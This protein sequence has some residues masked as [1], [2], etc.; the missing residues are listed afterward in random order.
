LPADVEHLTA[1]AIEHRPEL[2]AQHAVIA[3]EESNLARARLDYLPDFEV[4]ASRFFNA[5]RRDGFGGMVSVSLPLVHKGKYDAAVRE[6]TA[7]LDA[8]RADERRVENRIRR[9][10]A[11]AH[12]RTATARAQHALYQTSHI[13]LAEQSLQATESAY[14]TSQSDLT[15]VLESVR[16]IEDVHL[17]HVAFAAAFEKAYAELER[18]VGT[19]LPR[20]GG[21]DATTPPTAATV[22]P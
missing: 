19:E 14:Q 11:Q 16:M 6:I 22:R 21:D 15:A 18:A 8:A 13:P 2:A 20:G 17:E 3:R 10:V 7:R 12:L 5:D 1:L 4:T 9:E